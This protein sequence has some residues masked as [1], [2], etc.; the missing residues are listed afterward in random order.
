MNT[1]DSFKNFIA[2]EWIAGVETRPNIN[3]SDT[4]RRTPTT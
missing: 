4:D 3:P 1:M 2:G